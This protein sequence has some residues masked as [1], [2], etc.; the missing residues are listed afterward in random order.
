[1]S[2]TQITKQYLEQKRDWA[3]NEM[4]DPVADEGNGGR[5]E[6]EM[7]AYY[8]GCRDVYVSLLAE[9]FKEPSKWLHPPNVVEGPLP[10]Q[11]P[12]LREKE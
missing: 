3:Q 11:E 2:D 7:I 8:E 6:E 1:M 4:D 10:A 5:T 9:F 12:D